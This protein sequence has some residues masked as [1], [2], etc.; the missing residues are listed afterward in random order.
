MKKLLTLGYYFS[1][2]LLMATLFSGCASV[3]TSA[4]QKAWENRSTED[5]VTDSKIHT[6]ILDRLKN[7]DKGLLLDVNIDVWEQRVLLTGTLDDA[8]VRSEVEALAKQ[9]SRIKILHNQIQVVT[10][11]E[12][13]ARREQKEKGGDE[14]SGAGQAVNDFWI[15]TKIKAQLLTESNVGSV[16]YFYR[17]VLNKVYVIGEATSSVEKTLVLSIIR[18]TEGVKSVQEYI[19]ISEGY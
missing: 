1:V 18:D 12:K 9:D 5:Q 14:K 16:N 11:L 19:A 7:K 3:V 2:G 4:A 17:S 8:G 13:E 6:G 15:E 10:K